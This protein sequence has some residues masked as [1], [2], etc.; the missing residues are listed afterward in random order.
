VEEERLR[1]MSAT[2]GNI[3]SKLSDVRTGCCTEI[4]YMNDYLLGLGRSANDNESD[5]AK[6]GQIENSDSLGSVNLQVIL[7]EHDSNS[8]LR[9]GDYSNVN[10]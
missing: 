3:S 5:V 8:S 2:A 7:H 6:L 9:G 4:E 1:M 10:F